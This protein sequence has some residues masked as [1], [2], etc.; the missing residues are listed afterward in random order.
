MTLNEKAV[1]LFDLLQKCL[2]IY[3]GSLSAQDK[4]IAIGGLIHDEQAV[5]VQTY[6]LLRKQSVRKLKIDYV[7]SIDSLLE[8]HGT[9]TDTLQKFMLIIGIF[10]RIVYELMSEPANTCLNLEGQEEMIVQKEPVHYH[11]HISDKVEKN[12]L[13]HAFILL[14]A[15]ESLFNSRIYAG[16]DLEFTGTDPEYKLMKINKLIQMNFEHN[17]DPNS[18]IMII[19]PVEVE[20]QIL[21]NF[22]RLIMCNKFIIKILH[23]SDA[24]DIPYIYRRL[25][26]EDAGLFVKFMQGFIDS[27]YVCEFYRLNL[28]TNPDNKCSIY[29]ASLQL[30]IISEDK[31]EE[32]RLM[33]E[34]L[35]HPV[36]REWNIHKLSSSQLLYSQYD[37]IF[38]KQFYYRIIYLAS[39]NYADPTDKKKIIDLYKHVLF[40]L[41]QL[42]FL[43]SDTVKITPLKIKCKEEADPINNYM[44]RT[45]QKVL[46]LVDIYAEVSPG[47]ITKDTYADLDG[48]MKVSHFR[49]LISIILKKFIYTLIS[50]KYKINKDKMTVWSEKLSNKYV[51]DL[52][53]KM[54]FGYLV[55]V[56]KEAERILETRI[57]TLLGGK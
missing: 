57:R 39:E 28:Q 7:S 25:F 31:A 45:P 15:I 41:T 56:F 29:T 43:E 47:I 17:A 35:P 49:K 22:V 54:D 40:E 52:L 53:E 12:K 14:I 8:S 10:H 21:K 42:A 6:R 32:L 11:V 1:I 55:K 2:L 33:E 13:F 3:N 27:K 23:G 4:W 38:L 5:F 46:K 51:F 18:M 44:V 48:L 16:T 19:S 36:E 9:S 37:V 26:A 30:G 24:L 34:A 50:Q 20:E